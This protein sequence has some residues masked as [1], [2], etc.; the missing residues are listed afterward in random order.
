M[1]VDEQKRH[2]EGE[3]QE[4]NDLQKQWTEAGTAF[5]KARAAHRMHVS[6]G[7]AEVDGAVKER[8]ENARKKR[9]ELETEV[10]D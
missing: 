8:M 7:D 10:E 5:K 4:L 6:T 9:D 2:L 3:Q 1:G